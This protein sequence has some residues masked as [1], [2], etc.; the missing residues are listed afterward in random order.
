[1]LWHFP[2]TALSM[3]HSKKQDNLLRG[4]N[5]QPKG[6]TGFGTRDPKGFY[7]EA[8]TGRTDNSGNGK[9]NGKAS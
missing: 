9:L 1:M 8:E 3:K 7:T 5:Q 4:T 6:D 2:N